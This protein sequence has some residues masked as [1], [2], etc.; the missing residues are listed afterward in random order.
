MSR[1]TAYWRNAFYIQTAACFLPDLLGWWA[2]LL[3][4]PA[5][6]ANIWQN[7]GFDA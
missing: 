5:I 4:L 2:I 1:E 7:G 6:L 3:L